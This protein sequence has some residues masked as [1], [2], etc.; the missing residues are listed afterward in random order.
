MRSAFLVLTLT[1]VACGDSAPTDPD[2]P[3][4]GDPLRGIRI[5]GH[6]DD[7]ATLDDIADG[8]ASDAAAPD[9]QHEPSSSDGGQTP[10]GIDAAGTGGV[11][12]GEAG[13]SPAGTSGAGA[14]GGGAGEVGAAGSGKAG[15]G[16]AGGSAG[17]FVPTHEMFIG[18]WGYERAS[19]QGTGCPEP[20]V[21]DMMARAEDA[22]YACSLSDCDPFSFDADYAL[23][24]LPGATRMTLDR[25]DDQVWVGDPVGTYYTP[26]FWLVSEDEM[27]GFVWPNE[28]GILNGAMICYLYRAVRQ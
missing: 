17:E 20:S 19:F 12:G 28:N 8:G 13:A 10:G 22:T 18:S 1:L 11:E 4:D 5:P 16:G 6:G 15:A 7:V 25:W 23:Q 27:Y 14:G 2:D 3:N 21:A 26:M 9:D 24:G